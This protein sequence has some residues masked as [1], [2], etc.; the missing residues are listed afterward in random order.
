MTKETLTITQLISESKNLQN[1]I[2][3][4]V[5]DQDFK[6][7]QFYMA[8]K[9]FIGARTV[10]EASEHMVSEIDKVSDLLVRL[11]ALNKARLDANATTMVEVPELLSINDIFAGKEAKMEKITIAAAINRK[12]FYKEFLALIGNAFKNRIASA[13][14]RKGQLDLESHDNVSN[15]LD[16]MFPRDVQKNFSAESQKKAREELEKKH[17]VIRLDPKNIIKNEGVEKFTES[18]EQYIHNID[19]TLSLINAKTEVEVEY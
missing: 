12:R 18:V 1:Q 8:S 19:T 5:G 2:L 17:E 4:I 13:N 14:R 15:E 16:K 6:L 11:N 3:A 10:E 7:V 9:P